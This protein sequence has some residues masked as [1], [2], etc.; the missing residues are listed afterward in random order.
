MVLGGHH[1]HAII[2][3]HS[4][5]SPDNSS[6]TDRE[7]VD[8]S[9]YGLYK[10]RQFNSS[11]FS[12]EERWVIDTKPRGIFRT[13]QH[14]IYGLMNTFLVSYC[15]MRRDFR[16]IWAGRLGALMGVQWAT[17]VAPDQWNEFWRYYGRRTLAQKYMKAYGDDF[18]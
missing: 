6:L 10:L 15:I 8:R 11:F 16:P 18:L 3:T 1:P 13:S 5:H 17:L 9:I 4:V 7:K 14:A 12:P 2:D